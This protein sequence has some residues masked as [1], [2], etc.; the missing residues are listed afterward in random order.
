MIPNPTATNPLDEFNP[1]VV[2]H[3][4]ATYC[5]R[6]RSQSWKVHASRANALGAL[7]CQQFGA[8][9]EYCDSQGWVER[10]RFE[11]E[12]FAKQRCENCH[13]ELNVPVMVWDPTANQLVPA[14][15][16]RTK[17]TGNQRFD[18]VNG[19]L[20]EPLTVLTVCSVCQTALGL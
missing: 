11:R 17:Y 19:K 15:N 12:D 8:L 2:K 3:P 4:W 13:V 16:G 14:L 10:A 6:R 20:K 5:P 7:A 9:Y 18:R 1:N